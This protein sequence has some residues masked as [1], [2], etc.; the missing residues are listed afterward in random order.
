MRTYDKY[1]NLF[2]IKLIKCYGITHRRTARPATQRGAVR[3]RPLAT[4]HTS[5]VGIRFRRV[6]YSIERQPPSNDQ[7]TLRVRIIRKM[8]NM[9]TRD[10]VEIQAPPAHPTQPAN[11][12]SPVVERM[13]RKHNIITD[14]NSAE[15]QKH[16]EY[17]PDLLTVSTQ[18]SKVAYDLFKQTLVRLQE[19]KAYV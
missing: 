12:P 4:R 16:V 11:K 7:W 18:Y 5:V 3:A 15:I 13:K 8:C 1:V 2:P 9:C 14:P 10:V 19:T 6:I 17:I